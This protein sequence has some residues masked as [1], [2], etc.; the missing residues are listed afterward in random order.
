ML[1]IN[2]FCTILKLE[3][4]LANCYTINTFESSHLIS[5]HQTPLDTLVIPKWLGG[6]RL[7]PTTLAMMPLLP[8]HYHVIT[9]RRPESSASQ[10]DI[11]A[12]IIIWSGIT[13]PVNPATRKKGIDIFLSWLSIRVH[14][15]KAV[16]CTAYCLKAANCQSILSGAFSQWTDGIRRTYMW[17]ARSIDDTCQTGG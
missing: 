11:P 12:N 14:D 10:A 3:F 17:P 1:K 5:S 13:K 8:C 6:H 4:F 9:L 15:S 7:R 2:I 16:H